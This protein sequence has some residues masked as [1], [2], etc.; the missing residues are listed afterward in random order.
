MDWSRLSEGSFTGCSSYSSQDLE[1]RTRRQACERCRSYKLRC[2]RQS[3]IIY[4]DAECKRCLRARVRCITHPRLRMGRP[5]AVSNG[6][7]FTAS[8]RQ[9]TNC[10]TPTLTDDTHP[11]SEMSFDMMEKDFNEQS[12]DFMS[13]GWLVEDT[14]Q[15]SEQDQEQG[16]P[17]NDFIPTRAQTHEDD[18]GSSPF[19]IVQQREEYL[20]NLSR[21][22]EE[23]LKRL[24]ATDDEDSLKCSP[25]IQSTATMA[26]VPLQC[27]QKSPIISIGQLL[28]DSQQFLDLLQPFLPS[29]PSLA[30]CAIDVFCHPTLTGKS[31]S[32]LPN[33]A[34][35]SIET[36]ALFDS[37]STHRITNRISTDI[38]S[39]P[40]HI[41]A[42]QTLTG[43]NRRSKPAAT[44]HPYSYDSD[45]LLRLPNANLPPDLHSP[46]VR[47]NG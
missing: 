13:S 2:E 20:G 42:T 36:L 5:R 41:E 47:V 25:L 38:S 45:V 26:S 8:D 4:T 29:S 27:S 18:D 15:F 35:Q 31:T 11:T 1:D 14:H 22:S 17:M 10:G 39:L 28:R 30:E 9:L 6:S 23:L 21:L 16:V 37:T 32:S 7:S 3:G 12:Q 33:T 24:Y 19:A 34:N 46:R 40:D 43:A 44:Q